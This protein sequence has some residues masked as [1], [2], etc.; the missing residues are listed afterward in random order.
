MNVVERTGTHVGCLYILFRDIDLLESDRKRIRWRCVCECGNI[1]IVTSSDIKST[2]KHCTCKLTRGKNRK[3]S[4]NFK[5]LK[6]N[7]SAEYNTWRAMISRCSEKSRDKKYYY[8]RGISVS[9]EWKESFESF[10]KDMGKKPTNKHTLERIDNNYGYSPNNCK[11]ATRQEQL[12]NT[13]KNKYLTLNGQ[14]KTVAEWN[15]VAG[16]KNRNTIY[17]RLSKG[18]SVE[19][20]IMSPLKRKVI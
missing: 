13:R 18:W 3:T 4:E 1:K 7:H 5:H 10:L 16:F 19:E 9:K 17:S 2:P 12:N 14:T 6:L 8:D 15:R 11:W 20:A